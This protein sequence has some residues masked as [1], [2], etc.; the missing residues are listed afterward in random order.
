[1]RKQ[2]RF[3]ALVVILLLAMQTGA[4]SQGTQYFTGNGGRGMSLAILT[5]TPSG[6]AQDENYLPALIQGVLGDTFRRYSAIDV[7]DRQ[8]QEKI[9][10]EIEDGIYR[11][12]GDV[13]RYGELI[14]CAF[15]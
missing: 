15:T 1:M 11:E 12:T 6:L 9:I 5:P 10:L 14:P 8:A 7:F 4:F 2:Y 3:I 13:L